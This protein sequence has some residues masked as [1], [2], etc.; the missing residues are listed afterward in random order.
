MQVD[1]VEWKMIPKHENYEISTEGEV[2]NVETKELKI[3]KVNSMGYYKVMIGCVFYLVDRLMGIVYLN[4]KIVN[5]NPMSIKHK[6]NNKL[7]NRLE[8]LEVYDLRDIGKVNIIEGEEWK[9]IAEFPNYSVS[10]LARIKNNTTSRLVIGSQKIYKSVGLRHNNKVKCIYVHRLVAEAFIENTKNKPYV[11]HIDGNKSNNIKQNLEWVTA[12]EN[13]LHAVKTGLSDSSKRKK[14][15][16]VKYHVDQYDLNDVFIKRWNSITEASQELKIQSKSIG[17]AARGKLITAGGF[18]W[19][20]INAINNNN[21]EDEE[22]KPLHSSNKYFVS[23]FGRIKNKEDHIIKP[24]IKNGYYAVSVTINTKRLNYQVNRLVALAF[25][26]N[27]DKL[28]FVNHKDGNKLNNNLTNLEWISAKN[29]SIHAYKTGLVIKKIKKVIQ[30]D[31]DNNVIK[32]WDGGV[33]EASKHLNICDQTIYNV[34]KCKNISAGNFK[35][36]YVE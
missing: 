2:R 28:P 25:L 34:C 1:K 11:N 17:R 19:K 15:L 20:H 23:N 32:V 14:V 8:N 3:Y 6:N 33:K 26:V 35:W 7:D 9:I 18:K 4:Y 21:I 27:P 22:W 36:K 10:S 30:M 12:S 13:A 31:M 24:N 5:S 29:N 16:F